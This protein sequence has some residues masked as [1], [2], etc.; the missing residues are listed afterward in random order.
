MDYKSDKVKNV[1]FY[2]ELCRIEGNMQ[3]R[4]DSWKWMLTGSE[5]YWETLTLMWTET[6]DET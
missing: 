4:T 6:V 2:E 1:E 5:S 3:H